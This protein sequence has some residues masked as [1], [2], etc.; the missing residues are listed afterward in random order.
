MKLEII[1]AHDIKKGI[2]KAGDL[3][4]NISKDMRHFKKLSTTVSNDNKKNIVIMGR[5]TYESLPDKCRPLPDRLNIVLSSKEAG[6]DKA[7]WATSWEACLTISK[8]K[9][10]EGLAERVFVIGGASI[11]DLA[12][13]S[14]HTNK[15]WLTKV[16]DDF[17]CDTFFP[18]FDRLAWKGVYGSN[19]FVSQQNINFTFVCYQKRDVPL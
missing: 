10:D 3:P 18:N 5:K 7:I 11:Y 13:K 15:I 16:Y 19:I 17:K 1:V 9:T 12:L 4:W 8:E 6:D 14:E 2:G